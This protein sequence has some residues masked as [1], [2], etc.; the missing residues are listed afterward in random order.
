MLLDVF[1]FEGEPVAAMPNASAVPRAW[2]FTAYKNG[3]EHLLVRN[4]ALDA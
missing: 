2:L 3:H 1:S 4:A